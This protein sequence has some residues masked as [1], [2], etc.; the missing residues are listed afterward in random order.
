VVGMQPCENIN[1][2]EWRTQLA[3]S[4][5]EREHAAEASRREE[6]DTGYRLRKI[7][8]GT[9]KKFGSPEEVWHRLPSE[10]DHELG[11]HLSFC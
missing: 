3:L 4:D 6:S 9:V 11:Q 7:G 5:L 2:S 8:I 1:G 10:T